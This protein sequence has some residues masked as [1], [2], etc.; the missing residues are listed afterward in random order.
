MTILI[1]IVK[2]V[3]IPT[4][5]SILY[6]NWIEYGIFANPIGNNQVISKVVLITFSDTGKN[7]W[8]SVPAII[9]KP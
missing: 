8:T 4:K 1:T 7:K 2:F 5:G 6:L 9:P 3:I